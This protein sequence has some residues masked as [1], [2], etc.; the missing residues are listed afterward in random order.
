MIFS[1]VHTFH[2]KLYTIEVAS[3]ALP[4]SEST[5]KGCFSANYDVVSLQIS[6]ESSTRCVGFYI[7]QHI[8]QEV[9]LMNIAVLP[10]H[11]GKGYGAALLNDMMMR[12]STYSNSSWSLAVPI[13]LEVRESNQAA[14]RLYER[15]GF[16]LLGKRPDY[17]PVKD[18]TQEK[19]TALVYGRNIN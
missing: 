19:E 4:W 10:E 2:Q 12:Y 17:Y 14:I 9:T 13:F 8:A 5:L 7:C 1:Q 3:H 6:A 11:Q 18:P 16:S 15:Y